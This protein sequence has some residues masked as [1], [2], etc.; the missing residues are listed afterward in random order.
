MNTKAA[1]PQTEVPSL[2]KL[3][4]ATAVALAVAGAIL[5]TIVLPAEYGI[6]PLKTGRALGLTALSNANEERPKPA[7]A[8]A[9]AAGNETANRAAEPE[10]TFINPVLV[11]SPT[12]DAPTVK[13]VLIAQRRPFQFDSREITLAPGEGMEIKYNMRKGAGLVYSWTAGATLFYEFH[14]EPDVKPAGK[15]GTDYYESYDLDDKKGKTE[16]NG[17]FLAPS[18]GIHG[19]FWENKSDKPVTFKLVSAGYYD[20]IQQNRKEKHTALKPMDPYGFPSHPKIPDE[21]MK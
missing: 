20:W 7:P 9:E 18:T 16:S 6:D 19:W 8:A 13:D 2:K 4:T 1:V 21:I 11:P 3:L 17:T 15:Q 5:V 12:G 14:G 10:R